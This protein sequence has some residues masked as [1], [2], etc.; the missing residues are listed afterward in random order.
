M[1]MSSYKATVVRPCRH[2]LQNTRT[3]MD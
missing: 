1:F 3:T 2:E